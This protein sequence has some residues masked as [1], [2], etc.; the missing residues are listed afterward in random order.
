MKRRMLITLGEAAPIH[1][2]WPELQSEQYWTVAGLVFACLAL[3]FFVMAGHIAPLLINVLTIVQVAVLLL[4]CAVVHVHARLAS[5]M[6]VLTALVIVLGVLAGWPGDNGA[7]LLV[8]PLLLALT[9][10]G[11][12]FAGYLM[13]ALL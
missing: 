4:A 6:L 7:P 13:I 1:E 12:V 10:L 2:E 8:A 3:L 5:L 11:P 9:G